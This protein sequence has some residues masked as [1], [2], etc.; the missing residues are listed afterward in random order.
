MFTKT[1]TMKKVGVT[2]RNVYESLKGNVICA[3][4]QCPDRGM[5][6]TGIPTYILI[7]YQVLDLTL[8]PYFKSLLVDL[9]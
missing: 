1:V 2:Y 5:Q 9:K 7:A 8:K 6:A 3:W 4:D